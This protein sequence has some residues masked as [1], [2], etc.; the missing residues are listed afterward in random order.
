MSGSKYLSKYNMIIIKVTTNLEGIEAERQSLAHCK[1]YLERFKYV[2]C[3]SF[4]HTGC[5]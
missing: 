5:C 1:I 3:V 4:I 2:K